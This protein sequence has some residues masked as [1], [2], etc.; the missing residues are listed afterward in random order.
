MAR[1]PTQQKEQDFD[2]EKALRE[3]EQL[4]ESMEQGDL[5]LEQSLKDFERGIELTRACQQA[6]QSAEQRVKILLEKNKQADLA[7]FEERND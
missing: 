6:L 3:L 5:T 1:K 4:V 7:D 2:F